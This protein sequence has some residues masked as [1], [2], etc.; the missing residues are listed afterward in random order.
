MAERS[1]EQMQRLQQDPFSEFGN[2]GHTGI[3]SPQIEFDNLAG[4]QTYRVTY[5]TASIA[6]GTSSVQEFSTGIARFGDYTLLAAPYE[7]QRVNVTSYVS[8]NGTTTI[9]ADNQSGGT[10]TLNTGTWNIKVIKQR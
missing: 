6:H 1:R 5:A 10:K 3:D 2:H 8:G 7:L 4:V 9:L